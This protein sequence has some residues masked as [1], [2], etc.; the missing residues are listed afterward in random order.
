MPITPLHFGPGVAIKAIIPRYFS[1]S[2]FCFAQLVTDLEVVVSISLSIRPV[3]R[4]FHT[5]LG[6]TI[7]AAL[8]IIA[9]RPLCILAK[10]FWN[11][12]LAP[13]LRQHLSVP[14][15]ISFGAAVSAAFIGTYSH[16]L[17]DS[18][19]HSDMKPLAPFSQ[20]NSMLGILSILQIYL[21][22][23]ALGIIGVGIYG[24]MRY[25]HRRA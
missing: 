22:C 20:A 18:M 21:L 7:V 10:R 23:M 5:Y 13:N 1:F 14:E 16:V 11:A 8:S 9:G 24:Y 25:Y 2:I 3:H 6:A 12:R 4:F 19:M 15:P 17:L